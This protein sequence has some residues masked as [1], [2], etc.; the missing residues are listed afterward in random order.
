M[1][2]KS[3]C[4]RCRNELDGMGPGAEDDEDDG[5]ESDDEPDDG[6]G[7]TTLESETT[8]RKKN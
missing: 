5:S 3:I 2:E 6:E 7:D 4:K 8:H 1:G